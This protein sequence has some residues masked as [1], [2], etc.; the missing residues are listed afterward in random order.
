M[1]Q[2]SVSH[3]NWC[4]Q[5]CSPES[6]ENLAPSAPESA[7]PLPGNATLPPLSTF[8]FT[9]CN[10]VLVRTFHF[11]FI[12]YY[13]SRIVF[14]VEEHTI[15][16]PVRFPLP[17]DHCRVDCKE[18]R[19][20]WYRKHHITRSSNSR[21]RGTVLLQHRTQRAGL[22]LGFFGSRICSALLGAATVCS[23]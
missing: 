2:G 23:Q 20:P 9:Q 15:F 19:A 13:H 3:N 7:A 17:N 1:A 22:G 10:G 21:P 11:T 18:K 4:S 8:P 6:K 12:I 14:K 5:L 16:S